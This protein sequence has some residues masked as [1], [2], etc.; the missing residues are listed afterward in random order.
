M[1]LGHFFYKCSSLCSM[2]SIPIIYRQRKK[3]RL[4]MK[5]VLVLVAMGFLLLSFQGDAKRFLLEEVDKRKTEINSAPTDVKP[6]AKGSPSP[7]VVPNANKGL[8]GDSSQD[9]QNESY[10]SYGNPSGSTIDTHH[11]YTSDCQPGKKCT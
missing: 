8:K 4:I 5:T 10:G 7:T 2:L 3:T 11:V 9:D 6:T 1:K